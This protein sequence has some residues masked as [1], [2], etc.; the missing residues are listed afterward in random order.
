M[1][2]SP[3][4]PAV[5]LA[6]TLAAS[7]TAEATQKYAYKV[8]ALG[9]GPGSYAT[10]V[11]NAGQVAGRLIPVAGDHAFL[12]SNGVL[13]DLGTLPGYEGSLALGINKASQVVG[14]S[15][16][17]GK[18]GR[19]F[20]YSGGT[21]RDIGTLAGGTTA[22]MDINDAGDIVGYS[23]LQ[24]HFQFAFLYRDGLMR[25]L[26]SLPG[27]DRSVALAINNKGE[28]AGSSGV[29]QSEGPNGNRAHAVLWKHWHIRDLGTLGGLNSY[30]QDINERGQVVGYSTFAG[31][32]GPDQVYGGFIWSKGKMRNI[33]APRGG[34]RVMPL[35][36]NLRG[37]A[38]GMYVGS[39]QQRAFLYGYRGRMHDLTA[40]VDPAQGWTITSAYDINDAGQ[41][42]G[43]AC[44]QSLMCTAVRLDQVF[45][46]DHAG[47]AVDDQDERGSTDED[48]QQSEADQ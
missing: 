34:T 40:L 30:G 27:S 28:I 13:T 20:V 3:L 44:D 8:V 25:N 26:G 22:A 36:I 9:A 45:K 6:T 2:P 18:L 47:D 1:R 33:G 23:V 31:G 14:T 48:T 17:L 46:E 10:A 41:I 43:E 11:N 4:L 12:Y 39:N 42:A 21:M 5:L 37:Q 35:A 7:S 29:G 15:F 32:D 24:Q 16:G 19:A 38:V